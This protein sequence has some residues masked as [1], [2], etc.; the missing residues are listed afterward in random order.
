[1]NFDEETKNMIKIILKRN[2][3]KPTT[4]ALLEKLVGPFNNEKYA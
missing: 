1:V 2:V 3:N 4:K